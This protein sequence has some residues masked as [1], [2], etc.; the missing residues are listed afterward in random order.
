LAG[1]ILLGL[2]LLGAALAGVFRPGSIAGPWRLPPG[3]PV[4]PILLILVI[5]GGCWIGGQVA[6]FAIRA[7]QHARATGG[8]HFS[9]EHL[10]ASDLA[11]VAT[12][13]SLVAMLIVLAG[14][15][16]AGLWR[17]IGITLARL[18]R[19]ILTGVIG[20]VIA[21]LLIFG[22][23]S[24]LGA[25]Y[26]W[27][28]FKH[29]SEHEMLAAM[30]EASP[31]A[32]MILVFGACVMAPLFEE[33]LFRGHMQTLLVR[34]M[35]GRSALAPPAPEGMTVIVPPFDAPPG[36]VRD[37][38][39][40]PVGHMLPMPPPIEYEPPPPIEYAA[41]ASGGSVGA[42][43]LAVII[44]SI[45]FALVHPLWTA[46]LIFLLSVCLGYAYERT[47]S[48]WVPIVMHALFNIS[49]TFLFLNFV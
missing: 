2:G 27:I 36:I 41:L 24:L 3:S 30:K 6:F 22:A 10:T 5:G 11:L 32:K 29:P 21:M 20:G 23:S 17:P 15:L 16:M 28:H 39:L 35:S 38:M 49:S 13:P 43:W 37:S 31:I 40:P 42:R 44:T 7:Y 46:P 33:L 26:D 47:G 14:D 9:T 25:F 19:R 4:F 45:V 18:P 8:E 1:V 12:L 48:L 34:L